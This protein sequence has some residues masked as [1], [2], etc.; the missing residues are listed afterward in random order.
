M[1]LA[2][3][4]NLRVPED[5]SII[6]FDDEPHSCYFSPPL[7]AVWQPV[8]R[9]GMLFA[10]ILLHRLKEENI[11]NDFRKEVFKLELV[12]RSSSKQCSSLAHDQVAL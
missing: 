4:M 8:Y 2:K 10:R 12:I 5:I 6:G 9:L 1:H 11:Q 3:K 7:S